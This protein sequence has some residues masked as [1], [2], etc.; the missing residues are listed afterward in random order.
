MK[1]LGQLLLCSLLCI[2]EADCSVSGEVRPQACVYALSEGLSFHKVLS[3]DNPFTARLHARHEGESPH[4]CA[5]LRVG[6]IPLPKACEQGR[7]LRFRRR[8]VESMFQTFHYC[9]VSLNSV[10]V[11]YGTCRL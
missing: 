8:L 5:I 9:Q 7:S 3:L 11:Y 1:G 10:P 2:L 6:T 4:V